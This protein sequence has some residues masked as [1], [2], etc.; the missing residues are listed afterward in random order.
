MKSSI[1][2]LENNLTF[3]ESSEETLTNK[4]AAQINDS[5]RSSRLVD[6][7]HAGIV[8]LRDR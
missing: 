3:Y 5:T 6:D 2:R 8:E 7:I 1:N 4:L